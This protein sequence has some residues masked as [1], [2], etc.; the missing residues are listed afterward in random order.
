[1]KV[2]GMGGRQA[3]TG[4]EFGNIYDHFAVEYEYPNGVRVMS[5]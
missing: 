1:V 4:P 2:M 3:R 5:M